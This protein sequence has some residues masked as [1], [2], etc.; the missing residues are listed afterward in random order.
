MGKLSIYF[1]T[2]TKS[3]DYSIQ[4]PRIGRK[5]QS[6]LALPPSLM[7]ERL[8]LA[9]VVG[10]RIPGGQPLCQFFGTTLPPSCSTRSK[11]SVECQ[12]SV[13]RPPSTLNK[14]MPMVLNSPDLAGSPNQ[15]CS[16]VPE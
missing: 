4:F 3:V 9:Q 16:W 13:T 12:S 5:V 10:V 1:G 8:V 2:N 7:A 14:S 11:W 6:S 15:S